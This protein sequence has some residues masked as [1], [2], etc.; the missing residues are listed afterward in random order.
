[1]KILMF[2]GQS[3]YDVLRSCARETAAA[4]RVLGHDVITYD[5]MVLGAEGYQQVYRAW[6]PDLTVGFNP[7]YVPLDSRGTP[8]HAVTG[9]PHIV[10]LADHPY[11]HL[12]QRAL[13][14][15]TVPTVCTTVVNYENALQRLGI[16]G[17][18][19]ARAWGAPTELADA[20]HAANPRALPVLLAGTW[21]DPAEVLASMQ[22]RFTHDVAQKLMAFCEHW[23]GMVQRTQTFMPAL[24]DEEL[25]AFFNLREVETSQRVAFMRAAFPLAEIWYR[26]FV[27]GLI[28]EHL[29]KARVP[30]AVLGTRAWSPLLERAP[31]V[32][33]YPPMPYEDYRALGGSAKAVLNI[34]PVSRRFHDRVPAT[35]MA[36]AHLCSTA[37]PELTERL[38]GLAKSAHWFEWG[39]VPTLGERLRAT[40]ADDRRRVEEAA[41]GQRIAR[42]HLGWETLAEDILA[43][44]ATHFALGAPAARAA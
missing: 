31:N 30:I 37:M 4:L 21:A 23:L 19:R 35:L 15:P 22:E 18:T 5:L 40:L 12:Y 20:H 6:K 11:S 44:A 10:C 16:T 34:F 28:V 2:L 41:E 25:E 14:D 13:A 42:Q 39:D 24:M 38:P 32:S 29:I 17:W 7:V 43:A 26:H 36:G 27:R 9:T 3:Q 8:H 1:M 33:L